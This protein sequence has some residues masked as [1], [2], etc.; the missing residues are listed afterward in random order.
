M[1][2]KEIIKNILPYGISVKYLKRREATYSL[3]KLFSTH[4]NNGS[5]QQSVI[6]KYN[7]I[8]SVCGFGYSG[9][10]AVIDLLREYNSIGVLGNVEK[11]ATK[12]SNDKNTGEIDYLRVA[13]GLFDLE[14]NIS[15]SNIFLKDQA[16]HRF[17]SLVEKSVLYRNSPDFQLLTCDFLDEIVD[18]YIPNIPGPAYNVHLKEIERTDC[19]YFMKPLTIEQYRQLSS[20]YLYSLF[21]SLHIEGENILAADQLLSD[22]SFD[23]EHYRQYLPNVKLIYV[24]RDPRDVFAFARIKKIDWIPHDNADIFIRW[25]SLCVG[26]LTQSKRDYFTVRYEDLIFDYKD[27]VKRIEEYIGISSDKH[28]NIKSCFDPSISCKYVGLWRNLDIDKEELEKIERAL[29]SFCYYGT[30]VH[31][32]S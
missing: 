31:L 16:I 14:L 18:F 1:G 11:E 20:R 6:S 28:I 27:Q 23:I 8:I 10:G 30:T 32:I 26:S 2:Y 19:I 21:N 12:T 22:Y 9:S 4:R 17:I 24:Y 3:N 25:F 7:T 29:S 5:L 13:G 15:I